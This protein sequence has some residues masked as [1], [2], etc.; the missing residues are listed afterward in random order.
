M[1]DIQMLTI[2]LAVIV[3][4]SM[5]IYSNSRIG[6]AKETLEKKYPPEAGLAT[7]WILFAEALMLERE[8][9]MALNP[10]RH[11]DPDMR[12]RYD[13]LRLDFFAGLADLV[14]KLQQGVAAPAPASGR[15]Q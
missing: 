7:E 8:T 6:E 1:T 13:R 4:L 12:Q 14:E 9:A 3:P 10:K 15:V 11:M 2:G 5:L